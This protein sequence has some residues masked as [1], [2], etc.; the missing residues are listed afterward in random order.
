MSLMV[1]DVMSQNVITTDCSASVKQA[2]EL[3]DK[4]DIGCLVVLK[5][6]KPAGIVTER[7]MLRRVLLQF[8]DPETTNVSEVM[9]GPLISSN[10]QTSM[11]EA[12]GLLNERR[13][14]RLP[15]VDGDA[16]VGLLSM[17]DIVRSVAFLEHMANSLCARCELSR[18]ASGRI[19]E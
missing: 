12:M 14:K 4:Y 8:K 15:V 7:D 5:E 17:T 10:P 19:Q 9:S 16:V 13:I 6:G 18:N 11:R 2:A 3:M 1:R